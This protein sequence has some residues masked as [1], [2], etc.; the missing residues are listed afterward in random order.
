MLILVLR[1]VE[2]I[3]PEHNLDD[4]FVVS[5]II[6]GDTMEL[7]GGDRLR[8]LALDTPEEGETF[9]A[10]ATELLSQLSLGETARIEY[11]HRRRDKYGRLLGYLYI[12]SQFINKTVIDSGLGY[13]YLFS[14]NDLASD[15]VRSMIAA[16]R[17]AIERRVGLWSLSH[18]PERRYINKPGSF[19][20]HRPNCRSVGKLVPGRFQS[21]ATREEGLSTGLSPCRNCKP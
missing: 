8:L 17:S 2:D 3:G 19:R 20:L 13:V 6:D 9:Y 21:F 14:D 7:M 15:Q 1:L 10:E 16:Q 12:D 18:A 4:R 5:R 11:S